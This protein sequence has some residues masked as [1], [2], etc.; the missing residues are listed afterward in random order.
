MGHAAFFFLHTYPLL[1]SCISMCTKTSLPHTPV[2]VLYV[3]LFFSQ[4]RPAS[5]NDLLSLFC[6]RRTV[7]FCDTHACH[8]FFFSFVCHIT[9]LYPLIIAFS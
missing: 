5:V 2:D 7:Q 9:L 3:V 1:Y 4:F 8:F 6:L